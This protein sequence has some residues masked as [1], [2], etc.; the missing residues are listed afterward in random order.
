ML[1]TLGDLL[2]KTKD[3][4]LDTVLLVLDEGDSPVKVKCLSFERFIQDGQDSDE[5]SLTFS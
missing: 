1:M 3:M 5:F 4:P 2:E